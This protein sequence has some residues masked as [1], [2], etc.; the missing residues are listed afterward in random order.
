[1][2]ELKAK[3]LTFRGVKVDADTFAVFVKQLLTA[4]YTEDHARKAELWILRGNWSYRGKDAR[5]EYSDFFPDA[6]QLEPIL[7]AAG[8]IVHTQTELAHLC[9]DH[10]NRGRN[11]ERSERLEQRQAVGGITGTSAV[12]P[13]PEIARQLMESEKR[14]G[15]LEMEVSRA[16]QKIAELT[17]AGARD[18]RYAYEKLQNDHAVMLE[19]WAAANL[20]VK[21]MFLD[22][23]FY[24]RERAEYFAENP[25]ASMAKRKHKRSN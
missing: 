22:E 8:M 13:I 20:V 21:K 1:M 23:G 16:H 24:R 14:C 19:H 17:Q 2:V 11:D 4:R 25:G 18:L 15:D 3:L 10:Y 6:D 7:K 5:L 12:V 9:R